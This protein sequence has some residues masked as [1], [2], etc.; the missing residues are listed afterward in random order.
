MLDNQK[1]QLQLLHE[2][3]AKLVV[4]SPASGNV[5]T[6]NLDVLLQNR[7]V[8]RGEVLVSVANLAG[9]W[10]AELQVPDNRIGYLLEAER[11]HGG[12]LNISF[13]L[14]TDRGNP[15]H[16]ALRQIASRTELNESNRPI[17]RVAMDVDTESRGV[18]RPGA[19]VFA[20]INCGRRSIGYVWFHDLIDAL[21]NWIAY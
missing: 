10:T 8:Q 6:W 18:L 12:P 9:E 20:K 19:T 16:G 4:R 2:E 11:R 7:P 13:E 1:Q 3:R 15:Y 21:R 17:V 14:A 5:L